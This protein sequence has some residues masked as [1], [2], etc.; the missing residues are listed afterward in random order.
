VSVMQTSSAPGADNANQA[1]SILRRV[2]FALIVLGTVDIGV[3]IYCISHRISYSSS[4]NIFGVI[5]GIYVWRGHP[6]Y[7]RFVP[8]AAAFFAT[9][10]ATALVVLPFLMPLDLSLL[11]LRSH[12]VEAVTGLVVA[13]GF[14]VFLS[15]VYS[16]LR[17]EV[18][19]DS[20]TAQEVPRSPPKAAF[21]AGAA[22]VLAIVVPL[23]LV[24]NGGMEQRAIDLAK[25]QTG[26]GFRY[27]VSSFSTSGNHGRAVVLAYDDRTVRPVSVEW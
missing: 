8:R 22:L 3:M 17:S 27:W 9:G 10:F 7:V 23:K 15:W 1:R 19:I 14:I 24:A 11:E 26:P 4:F 16:E 5:S 12:V 20:Y 13:I 6:W 21:I 18:V 25:V 2:G